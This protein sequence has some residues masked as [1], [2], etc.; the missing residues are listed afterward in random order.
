MP[1]DPRPKPVDL[2]DARDAAAACYTPYPHASTRVAR[3][4]A[5]TLLT[6]NVRG[7][8]KALCAITVLTG[9]YTTV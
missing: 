5:G 6:G 2:S 7:L 3:E 1:V 8:T 4:A 9:W